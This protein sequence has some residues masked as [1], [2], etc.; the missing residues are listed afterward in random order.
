M[1][2]L[3]LCN[4]VI[5]ESGMEQNE[6][7]YDTWDAPE[8]GRRLYPRIKRAVREAWRTIQMERNEWEFGVKE[9]T[10]TILPRMAIKEIVI[11]GGNPGPMPGSFYKG[12]DSGLELEVL[13]VLPGRYEDT[14]YLEFAANPQYNRAMPG[15][16]FVEVNP[17]I[18]DSSFRYTGRGGYRNSDFDSLMREPHW[19]TFVG[20][21]GTST[22]TVIRYVPW[23]NWLYKE[24]SYT[25][26][27]RSAPTYFS[28]DPFGDIVFYPQTLDSF[29]LNF[30]YDTAPQELQ[31]PD[32]VP[33]T[34]LLPNEYHDWIAWRALEN[35]ARYDKNP[36]LMGWAQSQ[37]RLYKRKAERNLMP[38]PRWASNRYNY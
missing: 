4:K 26:A 30:Y 33:A 34:S 2:Y 20:Y 18:G 12:E 17:V 13:N 23:E 10:F 38:I 29:N 31:E 28:Q 36:D 14:Y 11:S 5:N 27:T 24:L 21:Q 1:D 16:I 7:T 35:I 37:S 19:T 22:P 9:G 6:L 3:A 32:D 25:T 8:A 15:E